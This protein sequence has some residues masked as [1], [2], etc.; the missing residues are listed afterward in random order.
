[1]R[2]V[3]CSSPRLRGVREA[4]L[5]AIVYMLYDASRFFVEG[6]RHDAVVNASSLLQVER[7][8]GI[9]WEHALNVTVSAHAA[10]A[11]TSAYLYA[12]LHYFITPVVLVWLWRRHHEVYPRA[13]RTLVIATLVG[14]VGF[15][16]LPIAPPRMLPGFVDTMARYAYAGWWGTDASAPRGTGQFTNEFAAM[17]SL[18]VGWALWCGWQLVQHARPL[19]VRVLGVLYPLVT[20]FVVIGTG[21]HYL[22]DAVAGIAVVL[23]ASTL[24]WGGRSLLVRRPLAVDLIAAESAAIADEPQDVRIVRGEPSDARTEQVPR[25]R[26]PVDGPSDNSWRQLAQHGDRR[27]VEQRVPDRDA[28]KPERLGQQ[29]LQRPPVARGAPGREARLGERGEVGRDVGADDTTA[30][31][32]DVPQESCP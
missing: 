20:T 28:V 18:H 8:A 32:G 27:T 16:L 25:S 12:S 4:S 9:A 22:L 6:H 5:V 3:T 10:L 21:N 1:M 14:L 17:P 24:E 30:G 15:T 31:R 23:I 13:R 26:R 29:P 19:A 11:I 7:A 2:V